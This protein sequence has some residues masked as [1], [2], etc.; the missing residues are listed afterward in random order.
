MSG[1]QDFRPLLDVRQHQL[2]VI[3]SDS[4]AV[5]TKALAILGA[6]VAILLFIDQAALNLVVWQFVAV[7]A[8]FVLSLGMD[9]LSIWPRRYKGASVAIA[10]HPEYLN[11][12][13][14]ELVL[15]LLGDTE[16]AIHYNRA[17]NQ[18]RLR[19]CL[20]SI[21]LTGFGLLTLLCII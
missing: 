12:G 19:A 20:A 18:Q 6:N 5:D 16:Y 11:L 17:L 4:D 9:V 21:I 7:Y 15:Q 14:Q 2:A 10:D 8:P 3:F 13:A 1:K